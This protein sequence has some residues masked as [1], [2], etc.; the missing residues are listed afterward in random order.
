MRVL[1]H[2]P[3]LRDVRLLEIAF[4]HHSAAAREKIAHVSFGFGVPLGSKTEQFHADFLGDV[5]RC[6]AET[7]GQKHNIAAGQ[8]LLY[9]FAQ[10]RGIVAHGRA[11]QNGDPHGRQFR[12]QKRRVGVDDLAQQQFRADG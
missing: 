10:T 12:R 1:E 6:G 8:C 3:A 4:G 9:R 2:D 5:V 11:P 7:A